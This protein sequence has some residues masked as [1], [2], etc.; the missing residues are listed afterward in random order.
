A[1]R[2]RRCATVAP[3]R[4]GRWP[5]RHLRRRV[6]ADRA[7]PARPVRRRRGD[8]RV[9]TALWPDLVSAALVG[10]ARRPVPPLTDGAAAPLLPDAT[11]EIGLL[12]AAGA[13]A[14]AR[15]A[16]APPVTGVVPPDPAPPE[17]RPVLPLVA[18]VR[19]R[20]LLD[21]SA[22]LELVTL[23]LTLAAERDLRAPARD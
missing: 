23:V 3:G 19:L 1:A 4:H 15:R 5:A 10:T 7:A 11:G 13:V 2:A 14:L 9:S 18:A 21:T 20:H 8:S 12:L 22:D 6:G 16:G 17:T